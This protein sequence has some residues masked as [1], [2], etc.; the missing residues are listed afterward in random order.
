VNL[1][2]YVA[3]LLLHGEIVMISSSFVLR[4]SL[5]LSNQTDVTIII[6]IIFVPITSFCN[7]VTTYDHAPTRE[8][9]EYSL[10]F[11]S[12][13]TQYL[14][15]SR[16]SNQNTTKYIIVPSLYHAKILKYVLKLFWTSGQT[17]LD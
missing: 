4:N 14:N 10:E 13:D 15:P 9:K 16:V 3:Y 12:C 2:N 8:R 1:P 7:T 11:V 6:A 5:I 17:L